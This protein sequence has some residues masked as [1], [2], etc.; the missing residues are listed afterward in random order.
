VA[1][2]IPRRQAIDWIRE[3]LRAANS[4]ALHQAVQADLAGA[5]V[6][7][8]F[9]VGTRRSGTADAASNDCS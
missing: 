1:D 5:I 8:E 2:A 3:F 6:R 4:H 9:F 7:D